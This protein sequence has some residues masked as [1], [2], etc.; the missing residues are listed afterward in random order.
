VFK[1]LFSKGEGLILN[2]GTIHSK[3]HIKNLNNKYKILY[4]VSSIVF[5]SNDFPQ[6]PESKCS[7][8]IKSNDQPQNTGHVVRSNA[9]KLVQ[10]AS[11]SLKECRQLHHRVRPR[12]H[13]HHHE[14]LISSPKPSTMRSMTQSHCP[15]RGFPEAPLPL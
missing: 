6:T 9:S 10:N 3:L 5:F 8:Y 4:L 14:I 1:A 15:H 12:M 11:K 7:S 13:I 2:L